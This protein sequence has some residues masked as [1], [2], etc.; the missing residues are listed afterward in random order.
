MA[1]RAPGVAPNGLSDS[2]FGLYAAAQSAIIPWK[3]EQD[4]R[5]T[6]SNPKTQDISAQAYWARL[7][8]RGVDYVFANAGTD[9]AP[10][11]E[12][13]RS[14]PTAAA[15]IPR[16]SRCRTKTWRWRWRMATTE[17]PVSLPAVMVHVTVGTGNT[18][19]GIM[20][21]ARDNIPILLAAG[22]TPITETGHKASRNRPIHWGSGILR[23]GRYGA[24]IHQVGLRTALR[25]A[26]RG[27]RRPCTRHRRLVSRGV[28]CT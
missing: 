18:V 6:M 23:P 4:G 1:V 19:N 5:W 14:M 10:L 8:E 3:R 7:A 9:F 15:S 27:R 13:W 21:A 12:F 24:R 11:I 25:A 20:N 22:R 26:G 17:L 28:P 2:R 16:S